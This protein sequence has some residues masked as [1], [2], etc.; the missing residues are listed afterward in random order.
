MEDPRD[1]QI[2]EWINFFLCRNPEP[3]KSPQMTICGLIRL[4]WWVFVRMPVT[5]WWYRRRA[6][7]YRIVGV[8]AGLIV[9]AVMTLVAG[10][11]MGVF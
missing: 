10:L 6:R 11:T 7:W 4:M 1:V 3:F 2:E 9:L 5:T 8:C